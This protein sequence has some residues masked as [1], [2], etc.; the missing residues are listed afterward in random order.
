MSPRL[1]SSSKMTECHHNSW[2]YVD[3]VQTGI[4]KIQYNYGFFLAVGSKRT[5]YCGERLLVPLPQV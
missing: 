2:S 1:V 5:R 3:K 4:K